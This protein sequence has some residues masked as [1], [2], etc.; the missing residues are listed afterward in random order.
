MELF[1]GTFKEVQLA[2][3]LPHAVSSKCKRSPGTCAYLV[4]KFHLPN[5]S[6]QYVL[7]K[8]LLEYSGVPFVNSLS[9]FFFKLRIY[10]WSMEGGMLLHSGL[11][12]SLKVVSQWSDSFHLR[13]GGK[14]EEKARFSY[15][16]ACFSMIWLTW[17]L[18]ACILKPSVMLNLHQI[19]VIY[20]SRLSE[21]M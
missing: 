4:S 9:I 1:F 19:L 7:L 3:F 18:I 16:F 21:K 13:A 6:S 8:L 11:F 14:F 2:Q 5:M 20:K 17:F 12:W 10:R 15:D